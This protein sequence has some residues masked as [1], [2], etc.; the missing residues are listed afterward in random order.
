M[1]SLIFAF[2]LTL[3]LISIWE[4]WRDP[5]PRVMAKK[6]MR[7]Y[8][9][10]SIVRLVMHFIGYTGWFLVNCWDNPINNIGCRTGWSRVTHLNYD[11]LLFY[12]SIN[13][14]LVCSLLICIPWKAI[15]GERTQQLIA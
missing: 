8:Q 2:N 14:L 6:L 12:T 9:A 4:Y 1:I 7:F 11:M 5:T 3:I 10:S 15:D 13:A